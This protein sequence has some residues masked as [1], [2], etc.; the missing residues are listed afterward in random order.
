M[1]NRCLK[2]EIYPV[3]QRLPPSYGNRIRAH[4]CVSSRCCVDDFHLSG[5]YQDTCQGLRL[6][7]FCLKVD[8][9]CHVLVII[10]Y[11]IGRVTNISTKSYDNIFYASVD[12]HSRNWIP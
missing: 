11:G 5:R 4:E 2:I 6:S 3:R 7:L 10:A 12:K 1:L 8:S 9:L